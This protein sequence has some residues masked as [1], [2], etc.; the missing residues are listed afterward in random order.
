MFGQFLVDG[1]ALGSIYGVLALSYTLIFGVIR[2]VNFAQ[3]EIITIGGF[4]ALAGWV[5]TDG[6]PII[7]R[8]A[9]MILAAIAASCTAGLLM[10]CFLFRPLLNRNAPA[11]LGLI[12]SLGISI[13]IQNALRITISSS[14]KL[15][16]AL[17]S[18]APINAAGIH[19]S[20]M[21]ITLFLTL[22]VL[23]FSSFF[24]VEKTRFG[25]SILAVRD[26]RELALS[27][28][29]S[30][31]QITKGVFIAASILAAFGGIMMGM[32]YN[33]VRFDIG[34]LP[35][36]KAFT[37]SIMGGVGNVRGAAICGVLL[38]LFESLGAGYISSAYKD[39]F[40]FLILITVLLIRPQGLFGEKA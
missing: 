40:A 19:I 15:F 1:L 21:Q 24:F 28:G 17:I 14:D 7:W 8:F 2:V 4:G 29:I 30:V 16:P 22:I 18:Q 33:V 13:F 9:I 26:N 12:A 20:P 34:F 31:Q 35:G 6:L 37:A 36:I 32:Y 38:G 10:E 11:L 27:Y 3:G 25:L 5:S 23:S 39:G